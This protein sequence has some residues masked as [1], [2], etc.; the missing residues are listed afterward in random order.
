MKEIVFQIK[1][2]KFLRN[3]I[4]ILFS[5][6]LHKIKIEV[7]QASTSKT[8]RDEEEK[9]SDTEIFEEHLLDE[10]EVIQL[11]YETQKQSPEDTVGTSTIMNVSL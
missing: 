9:V 7:L 8:G 5:L 4:I 3:E 1:T 11:N 10:D 6:N 2:L